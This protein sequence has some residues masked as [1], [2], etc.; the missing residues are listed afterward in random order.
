M[1]LAFTGTS[2]QPLTLWQRSALRDFLTARLASPLLAI[3][4]ACIYADAE[5]D[6]MCVELDVPRRVYPSTH[7][8]K[9]ALAQCLARGGRITVVTRPMDPLKRNPLIVHAA[10]DLIACPRQSHEITRSG[11]WTTVRLAR[12]FLG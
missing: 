1:R 4:G 2:H 7:P 8:T 6:A 11:T 3:H 5:F 9:S 12:R 10:T